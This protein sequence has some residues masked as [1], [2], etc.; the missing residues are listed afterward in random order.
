MH[1]TNNLW[2]RVLVDHNMHFMG[3]QHDGVIDFVE[4]NNWQNSE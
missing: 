4:N 3:V 1:W 2:S